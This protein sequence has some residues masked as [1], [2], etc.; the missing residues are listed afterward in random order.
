MMEQ[1]G[2]VGNGRITASLVEEMLG[3]VGAEA[4][5][6]LVWAVVA[7]GAGEA[8][9]KFTSV[10]TRGADLKFLYLSVVD[11][12]RDAAVWKFTEQDDLLYR[13]SPSSLSRMKELFFFL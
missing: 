13:H 7:E 8:I 1:G 3:L 4:A 6:D 10:W 2:V 11:A 9:R 5:I 12:L